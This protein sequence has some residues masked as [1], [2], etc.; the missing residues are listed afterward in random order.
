MQEPLNANQA[1]IAFSHSL[2]HP[3]TES[4]SDYCITATVTDQGVTGESL[5]LP[6]CLPLVFDDVRR[7]SYLLSF[8]T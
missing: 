3:F 7:K 6:R 1:E 8:M 2:H 4:V 5:I